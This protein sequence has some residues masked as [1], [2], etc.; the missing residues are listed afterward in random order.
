MRR[1][2]A[3]AARTRTHDAREVIM[4]VQC[5]HCST[6]YLL[7]D[8]LLGSRGAKVRC[9]SCQQTFT[10]L[11]VPDS[12]QVRIEASPASSPPDLSALPLNRAPVP[13]GSGS[14]AGASIGVSGALMSE[15][16]ELATDGPIEDPAALAARFLDEFSSR[17]GERLTAAVARGQLLSEL[18]PELLR[19][20]DDFRRTLV[21]GADAAVFRAA[22]KDRWGVDL[23]PGRD[24]SGG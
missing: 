21:K 20:Y 11:R 12:E 2:T 17:T 8:Y 24:G 5:P 22:V 10:V 18:G 19:V 15:G 23:E 16:A 14:N 13:A 3:A 7:P 6:D 9:P 4:T 1:V